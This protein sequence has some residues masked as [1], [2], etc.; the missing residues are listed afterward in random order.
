MLMT[1]SLTALRA[2]AKGPAPSSA[3]IE[4]K[5][6]EILRRAD[7]DANDQIS[8]G[9]F[10]SFVKHDNEVLQ[11]LLGY[12]LVRTEDLGQHQGEIHHLNN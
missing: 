4:S 6:T 11:C 2:M 10:T 5:T 3:E 7:L 1:N 8:L 12:G 9:E